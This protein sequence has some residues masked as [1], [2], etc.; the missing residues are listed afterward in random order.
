MACVCGYMLEHHL[1]ACIRPFSFPDI[2]RTAGF[3]S[4]RQQTFSGGVG[5]FFGNSLSGLWILKE[6]LAERLDC[7][8]LR[9]FGCILR[10]GTP[11]RT[12]GNDVYLALAHWEGMGQGVRTDYYAGGPPRCPG[13]V[14]LDVKFCLYR[15][16]MMRPLYRWAS[17]IVSVMIHISYRVGGPTLLQYCDYINPCLR[18]AD[19][20]REN[21]VLPN[22]YGIILGHPHGP[23]ALNVCDR[24]I[25][26]HDLPRDLGTGTALLD[27]NAVAEDVFRL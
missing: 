7:M 22:C 6:N 14:S 5:I 2:Y 9:R 17:L 26:T 11:R 18:P 1:G 13:G 16:S 8:Y 20:E 25:P 3:L 10:Y 15:I 23:D 21:I 27:E 4:H 24:D 12:G 19:L